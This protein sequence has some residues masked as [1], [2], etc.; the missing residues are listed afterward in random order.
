M[1]EDIGI[2]RYQ[3][4]SQPSALVTRCAFSLPSIGGKYGKKIFATKLNIAVANIIVWEFN[5]ICSSFFCPPTMNITFSDFYDAFRPIMNSSVH[6]VGPGVDGKLFG[7]RPDGD[8]FAALLES[9]QYRGYS[10]WT[11]A[12]RGGKVIL[13]SGMQRAVAL[14]FVLTEVG[15][16]PDTRIEVL[17]EIHVPHRYRCFARFNGVSPGVQAVVETLYGNRFETYGDWINRM[18]MQWSAETGITKKVLTHG[19]ESKFDEWLGAHVE[20]CSL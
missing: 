5:S 14:A 4:R 17:D 18:K 19:Q 2:N 7:I 9:S 1:Q 12:E 11:V 10:V 15:C 3:R 6:A 16:P 20:F 8:D 13:I